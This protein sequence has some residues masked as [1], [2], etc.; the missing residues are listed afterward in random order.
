MKII[1]IAGK[2]NGKKT[3]L[4]LKVP[5]GKTIEE[6]K[7]LLKSLNCKEAISKVIAKGRL[8]KALTEDDM[9]HAQSDLILTDT[10]AYWTLI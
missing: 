5:N 8:I 2:R 10:N 3:R 7:T 4:M 6:I 9:A 1:V